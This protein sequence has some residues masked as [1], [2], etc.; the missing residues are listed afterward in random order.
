VTITAALIKSQSFHLVIKVV[1]VL[2]IVAL[3]DNLFLERPFMPSHWGP[4]FAYLVWK[5][6]KRDRQVRMRRHLTALDG[7]VW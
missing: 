6:V 3:L 5:S 7:A 2:I 1:I 4:L